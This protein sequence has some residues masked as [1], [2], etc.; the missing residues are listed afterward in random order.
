MIPLETA[1]EEAG[2]E[3]LFVSLLGLVYQIHELGR[4]DS[5]GKTCSFASEFTMTSKH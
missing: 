1:R 3:E 4:E 2:S 5:S